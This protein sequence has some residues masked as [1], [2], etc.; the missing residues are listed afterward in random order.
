MKKN[1]L[2]LFLFICIIGKGFCKKYK[3]N[4]LNNFFSSSEYITREYDFDNEKILFSFLYSKNS[5]EIISKGIFYTNENNNLKPYLIIDNEKIY[6]D[7]DLLFQGIIETQ[8]FYGYKINVIEADECITTVF[9]TDLGKH[10]TEGPIFLW[11]SKQ[12]CFTKYEI[13]R[14]QF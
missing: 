12:K 4:Y 7:T 14:S 6:N 9:C 5:K 2:L 8:K 11:N 3:D 13:D 1:L 10:V